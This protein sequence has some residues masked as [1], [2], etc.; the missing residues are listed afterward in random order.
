MFFMEVPFSQSEYLFKEALKVGKDIKYYSVKNQAHVINGV[1]Q[2]E[3]ICSK[4]IEMLSV[5]TTT[6][7]CVMR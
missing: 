5:S 3:A 6:E 4:L 7:L 1:S 2:N